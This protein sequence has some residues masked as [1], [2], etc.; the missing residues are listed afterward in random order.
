ML[1]DVT[2][3][4]LLFS[5]AS[6]WEAISAVFQKYTSFCAIGSAEKGRNRVCVRLC[7]RAYSSSEWRWFSI[8]TEEAAL[9][10]Y[11]L[12]SVCTHLARGGRVCVWAWLDWST[13]GFFFAA[14]LEPPTSYFLSIQEEGDQKNSRKELVCVE[15]A[16]TDNTHTHKFLNLLCPAKKKKNLCPWSNRGPLSPVFR[17]H[18]HTNTSSLICMAIALLRREMS[19]WQEVY[20]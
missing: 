7:E 13:M 1:L 17:R 20:M 3:S 12:K 16:G 9:L 18:A 10:A 4:L 19:W 11:T 14:S 15:C 5:P 2:L 6:R 8:T